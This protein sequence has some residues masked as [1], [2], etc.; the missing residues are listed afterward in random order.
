MILFSIF[1]DIII[2]WFLFCKLHSHSHDSVS[3]VANCYHF[4]RGICGTNFKFIQYLEAEIL[5]WGGSTPTPPFPAI[6]GKRYT[7][8]GLIKFWTQILY[9]LHREF[10]DFFISERDIYFMESQLVELEGIEFMDTQLY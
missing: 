2:N 4:T 5:G 8:E 10:F 3:D 7:L 9:G 1:Y 6:L